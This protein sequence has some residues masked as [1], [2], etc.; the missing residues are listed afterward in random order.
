MLSVVK[1]LVSEKEKV[2]DAMRNDYDAVGIALGADQIEEIKR[3]DEIE[4]GPEVPDLDLVYSHYLMTFGKI[5]L[6]DPPFTEAIDICVQRSIEI[7][8]LDMDEESYADLFCDK[9]TTW[10][11]FKEDKIAK[12][13]L[14]HKFNLS[15]PE[16]FVIDWDDYVNK[17]IKGF[18]LMRL[19]REA[20]IADS[21]INSVAG[22]KNMLVVLELERMAGVLDLIGGEDGQ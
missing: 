21:I 7:V 10:E 20:F 16:Q 1:G 13:A 6:P 14:K 17:K 4:E 8:P 11:L 22:K 9:V 15:S 3:R 5:D 2:A 19:E 18:Y 12:K